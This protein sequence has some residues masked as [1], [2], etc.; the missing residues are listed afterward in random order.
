VSDLIVFVSHRLSQ[1]EALRRIQA[2]VA[3]A[4]VQYSEKINDLR[5]SWNGYVGTF[6]ISA[7]NQQVSGTVNVNPSDVTIQSTL[8]FVASLFKSGIESRLRDELTK[9]L[10]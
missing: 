3:Q 1:D 9:I 6:Q 4:K 10:A 8:P 2:V 5:E 7:Q